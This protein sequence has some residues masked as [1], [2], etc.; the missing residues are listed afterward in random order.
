MIRE[1]FWETTP[2]SDMTKDEW[3]A[4]CDKCG[5]CCLLKLENDVTKKIYNTNIACKLLCTKT[6]RCKDYNNRLQKVKKCIKL[7]VEN[8]SKFFHWMPKTC[9]YRLLYEGKPL[10]HW[11]PILTGKPLS[12]TAQ[13]AVFFGLV[14]ERDVPKGS[15]QDHII[16]EE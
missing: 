7:T 9:S 4:L 1:N 5:K 6:A 13:S 8:I 15:E 16:L 12:K 14:T 3:E 10:P 2:L 11:H